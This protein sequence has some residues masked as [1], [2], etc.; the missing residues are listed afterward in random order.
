MSNDTNGHNGNG[1]NGNGANGNGSGAN[2][3]GHR[4]VDGN[5]NATSGQ[6]GHSAKEREA[7]AQAEKEAAPDYRPPTSDNRVMGGR[8]MV[9][10]PAGRQEA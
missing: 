7:A 2:G 4:P 5:L 6:D 9:G 1:A 3:N 8:F 10:M